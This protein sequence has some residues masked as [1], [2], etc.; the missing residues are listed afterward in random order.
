MGSQEDR[1][2]LNSLPN[3]IWSLIGE[4]NFVILALTDCTLSSKHYS[5]RCKPRRSHLTECEDILYS[6]WSGVDRDILVIFSSFSSFPINVCKFNLQA[7]FQNK[8]SS[9]SSI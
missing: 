9:R 1:R 3:E 4:A 2:K 5:G 6:L 7:L 8:R